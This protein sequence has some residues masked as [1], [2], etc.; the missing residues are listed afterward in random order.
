PDNLKFNNIK[1]LSKYTN[2]LIIKQVYIYIL[3]VEI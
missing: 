2:L 1:I 3:K